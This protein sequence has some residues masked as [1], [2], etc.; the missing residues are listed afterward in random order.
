MARDPASVRSDRLRPVGRA[1]S[2]ERRG[3]RDTF[4]ITTD[5]EPAIEPSIFPPRRVLVL[6]ADLGEGHDSAARALAAGLADESAGTEVVLADGLEALGPFLQRTIRDGSW[7]QFRRVPWVFG[8]VYA[9]LMGF[10]P[11]RRGAHA[12]LYRVGA[13]GLLGLIESHEPDVVVSTYPGINPVLGRLRRSS[14]LRAPVCTTVLDLA[15]LEFWAHPG[16]DLHLVMHHGSNGRIEELAGPGRSHQVRPLVASEYLEPR[17]AL[18]ARRSLG[19]PEVGRIVL[20]TG[21]GWGIGDLDGAVSCALDAG[22]ATVVCVAGRNEEV[23][24]RL[25]QRFGD[26]ARVRVLGFTE[27]M[28][29]LIA[30]ADALVHSGGGVTCLE[31][32]VTGCPTVLYGMPPGHWRANARGMASLGVARVARSS[33]D[34]RTAL[35]AALEAPPPIALNG[36]TSSA[37]SLVLQTGSGH[38]AD[39]A[40]LALGGRLRRLGVAGGGN[41]RR[42]RENGRSAGQQQH[43]TEQNGSAERSLVPAFAH[44]RAGEADGHDDVDHEHD[45]RDAGGGPGLEGGHLAQQADPRGQGRGEH[46]QPGDTPVPSPGGIRD[47]LGRDPAP[48]V[49]E[50]GAEDDGQARPT[51]QAA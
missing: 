46:P 12:F 26:D 15:S 19:L 38:E 7:F 35:G 21:G 51:P 17:P 39:A 13:K 43:A 41:R 33:R 6:S 22:V 5:R 37:A 3:V 16:I 18:E 28:R 49:G 29:D 4:L 44:Q 42:R 25:E 10:G 32:L 14:R 9:L 23:R 48:G 24:E 40:G 30:A 8:I 20:V 34:L 11:V 27:R 45:G 36:A 2:R 50:P 47:E 1:P 31:G